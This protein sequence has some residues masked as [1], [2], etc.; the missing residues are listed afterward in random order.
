MQ[1]YKATNGAQTYLKNFADLAAA[2]AYFIPILGEGF[3][4]SLA[5]ENEQ[6]KQPTDAEKLSAR[7]AFG[8]ELLNEYLLDNDAIASARGYAFTVEETAQQAQKFQLVMGILPLGSLKQVL[9]VIQNT[10]TD[11]IFT[12]ARK[13]KYINALNDFINAQG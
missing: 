2:E 11:T 1:T 8:R 7:Q 13:D 5:N 6:I 12:Q 10:A 3:T 4:V 9:T